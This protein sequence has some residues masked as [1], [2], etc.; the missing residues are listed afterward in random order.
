MSNLLDS[1]SIVLTPTA[2]D[3]GKML[4]VKPSAAL[5]AELVTNGDFSDGTNNWTATNA[6]ISAANNQLTVDDSTNL[7]SD[8]RATQ[9]FAT[10]VGKK[11]R[12]VFTRVSTTSLFYLGIGGTNSYNN[13]FYNNLGTNTGVYTIE[14]TATTIT[15]TIALITGGTGISVFSQVSVKE[16]LSGDFDFSRNSAAT[17]VNAQGLVENVQILSGDLV[18]NGDFSQEGVQEVSNGSF[19]QEGAELISAASWSNQTSGTATISNGVIT[20]VNGTGYLA[21]GVISANKFY[22]FVV[23]LSNVTQGSFNITTEGGVNIETLSTNGVHEFYLQSTSAGGVFIIPQSNFTG[24]IDNVSVKEVG[25]DWALQ[26]GWSI[27]EDKAVS[28]GTVNKG[29]IQENIFTIGKTYKI[30]FDVDVT[31]GTLSSRIRFKNDFS[32]TT[33]ANISSSGSYTFYQ[34]ADRT[35]LQYITLSDN[36]ATS[37]IT[38]ISVKEVGQDWII[39]SSDANNYV[40][41][42]DGTARLKFLNTSPITEFFTSTN[43]MI[44]GKTYQLTV[45][46]A[47]ATSGSIKIDGGGISQQVFNTAGVNTR[48]ISP[49][50]NTN[51]KFYRASA[52]VDITLNSVSLIE[53]TDDTNLPRIN[54]EGFSYQDVLGSEEV[55]NGDF[56]TDSNWVKGTGWTISNGLLS[57]DGTQT[58]VSQVYQFGVITLGTKYQITFSVS[59]YSSGT[60][61]AGA[62]G[63]WGSYYSDN[64]TYTYDITSAGTLFIIQAN[65]SFIG[66]IDNVSVKEYLGQEVVPDSGC[67]SWLLEPQ[68]TNLFPF[69]EDFSQWDV[70]NNA[71]ILSSSRISPDGTQNASELIIGSNDTSPFILDDH[72]I[73]VGEF[74]TQTI[75]AKAGDA[76]ILQITGSSGFSSNF[77][78]YNLSNGTLGNNNVSATNTITSI[79][80]IGNGWYRCIYTSPAILTGSGRIIFAI[81]SEG[82][83]RLGGA[84]LVFSTGIYIWGAMVEQQSYATSYIPTNGAASTRLQDIANNSGNATLINSTEGVLYAEVAALANDPGTT[85]SIFYFR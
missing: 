27:G 62:D 23:T 9:A 35:G 51:I 57:C 26:D 64:G 83:G 32:A 17:R 85:R 77:Q 3:N 56:A 79:E 60:I 18:S 73:I 19:S 4:S 69:S 54:Y 84:G 11:Y 7:G 58:S 82:S 2:Y 21:Q 75:Y 12:L 22:K 15:S 14:F 59:N 10:E 49:T 50:S 30:T 8:S 24:S 44:G 6:V 43:L 67:G 40:E 5:G 48:I 78:N 68:S 52:N 39:N 1:A 45:D 76:D 46:I 74:Y 13:I 25:Q 42:G 29:V 72:S 55:V 80:D 38:N 33:I 41:F 66:S 71:S 36:A 28:D 81:V 61:R 65:S 53:I 20:F 37:S 16:D 63:S 34:E 70:F 31:S 47:E